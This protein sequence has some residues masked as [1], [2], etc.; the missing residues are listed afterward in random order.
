MAR[1]SDAN[2]LAKIEF[3]ESV[4]GQ[5][6]LAD[7]LGVDPRTIRK[8]KS[9]ERSPSEKS[10]DKTHFLWELN[11]E[12]EPQKQPKTPSKRTYR[13][14]EFDVETGEVRAY[15]VRKASRKPTGGR[16]KFQWEDAYEAAST[17]AERYAI[18]QYESEETAQD[19]YNSI[20]LYL[21]PM[22]S[23]AIAV[24][25]IG[26][27][28]VSPVFAPSVYGTPEQDGYTDYDLRIHTPIGL[29]LMLK[30]TFFGEGGGEGKYDE[31]LGEE[32]DYLPDDLR[33]FKLA[34]TR[35]SYPPQFTR[36]MY[37]K[38]VLEETGRKKMRWHDW[39]IKNH[40][41]AFNQVIRSI[42]NPNE[43]V[44]SRAFAVFMQFGGGKFETGE[45]G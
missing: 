3:L 33:E 42:L 7:K 30:E 4:F 17:I 35:M 39:R 8:W 15:R 11:R 28:R 22:G 13:E 25:P 14:P 6:M 45:E 16:G 44:I 2:F 43:H 5:K 41:E 18:N 24:R 32:Y 36:D 27:E 40:P 34:V 10:V 9:E 20:L 26:V 12:R 38:F 31:T 23:N 21:T 19:I 37:Q 1:V 29:F